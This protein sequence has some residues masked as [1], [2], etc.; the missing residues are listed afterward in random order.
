MSREGRA[1]FL[2]ERIE[3]AQHFDIDTVAD[4][5]SPYPHM[6]PSEEEFQEH[7]G[8]VGC[9]PL[10]PPAPASINPSSS[11]Y[12]FPPFSFP[13]SLS[14]LLYIPHLSPSPFTSVPPLCTHTYIHTRTRTHAHTHTHT[15]LGVGSEDHVV[16]YDN[17]SGGMMASPRVWW[18]FRVSSHNS[19]A[20]L[21]CVHSVNY[22]L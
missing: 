22:R 6:V 9:L 5:T 18:L 4:Q 12:S 20:I 17:H 7:V 13:S 16:V 11:I 3:G 14:D 10:L 2:A 19:L 21:F 8:K 1:A 15:Q